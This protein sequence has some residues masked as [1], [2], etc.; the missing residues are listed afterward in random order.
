MERV[1]EHKPRKDPLPTQG[2]QNSPEKTWLCP[3]LFDGIATVVYTGGK[4]RGG[5]GF[6]SGPC[7]T[8]FQASV[9]YFLIFCRYRQLSYIKQTTY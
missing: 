5:C 1:G 8:V 9:V 6:Q 3:F 4:E 2:R 7:V